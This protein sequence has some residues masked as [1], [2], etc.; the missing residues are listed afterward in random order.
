MFYFDEEFI[1][2]PAILPKISREQLGSPEIEEAL[3]R[4]LGEEE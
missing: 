3:V 4:P 2:Q 1:L